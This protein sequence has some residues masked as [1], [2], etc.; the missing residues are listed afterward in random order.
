MSIL[1]LSE[2]SLLTIRQRGTMGFWKILPFLTL[3][4]LV[5]YHLGFLQAAPIGFAADNCTSPIIAE[6]ESE[7]VL[8]AVVQGFDQI[9]ANELD[10]EKETDNTNATAEKKACDTTACLT[11][12][13]LDLLSLTEDVMKKDSV[14]T[15]VDDDANGN[16]PENNKA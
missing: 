7:F 10:L 9:E 12:E 14:P 11:R 15:N 16:P 1:D 2:I 3:S 13:L 4:I 6:E 8:V 5:L